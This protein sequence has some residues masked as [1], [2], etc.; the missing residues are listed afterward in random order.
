M[1]TRLKEVNIKSSLNSRVFTQFLARDVE[2]RLQRDNV[3][4]FI[5]LNMVDNSTIEEARLFNAS[6][7]Q[8]EIIK[9]GGVYNAAVD[10]KPYDKSP[11]GYSC[12]I[13]NIEESSEP[14]DSFVEWEDGLE[15]CKSTIENILGDIINTPYGLIAYKI[16]IKY[17]DKFSVWTAAKRHHHIQL[18]GLLK[19]T[20]EV[21][22]TVEI[23]SDYYSSLY[24][25]DFINRPLLMASAVIHDVG[26]VKELEV[27][28]LSGSTDYS[29]EASLSTHIMNVLSDVEVTAYEL[30]I[31]VQTYKVNELNE[32]EPIK[33]KEQL[34][35]E[36]ESVNLL[37]HV[38]ASH[39]GKL[40]WGSPITASIPEAVILHK[41]D[42]ISADM[43]KFNKIMNEIEP[44]ES[45]SEWY[46]GDIR[47]VYKEKSK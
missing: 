16:I 17:W 11:T 6:E 32:E 27:E 47:K 10:V 44:G 28:R 30:G 4:K 21:V 25:E 13:Y 2:V 37:R 29:C 5:V 41:M 42:E 31:G 34:E 7:D 39:H 40:E 24:G 46:N 43:Y 9:N 26:K 23:I 14:P 3:K 18:G 12:I 36:I 20:A 35:E 19:H 45:Y 38:L 22:E 15:N 33:S 1:Y 8:I